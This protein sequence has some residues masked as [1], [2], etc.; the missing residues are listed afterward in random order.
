[1]IIQDEIYDYSCELCC[2]DLKEENI[3]L[4]SSYKQGAKTLL[5]V[6]NDCYKENFILKERNIKY[7]V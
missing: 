7:V 3:K 5:E 2:I 4:I 1:M 6:C